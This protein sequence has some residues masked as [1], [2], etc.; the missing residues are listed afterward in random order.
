M[1]KKLDNQLMHGLLD[2]IF[3]T[4]FQ[5]KDLPENF[6]DLLDIRR[7]KVTLEFDR[8]NMSVNHDVI[9]FNTTNVIDSDRVIDHLANC[10]TKISALIASSLP[11]YEFTMMYIEGDS[12]E[13][14]RGPYLMELALHTMICKMFLMS[15]MNIRLQFSPDHL[16]IEIVKKDPKAVFDTHSSLILYPS[17]AQR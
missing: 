16:W 14:E 6:F 3:T 15:Q 12:R 1:S 8:V 5:P 9:S 13:S 2:A 7:R 10:R 11:E 4:I 17:T